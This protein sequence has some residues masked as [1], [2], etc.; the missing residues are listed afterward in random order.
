[1]IYPNRQTEIE[2]FNAAHGPAVQVQADGGLNRDV[3]VDGHSIGRQLWFAAP[4]FTGDRIWV[5]NVAGEFPTVA[6][7]VDAARYRDA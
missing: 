2:A 5:Q 1:M 4:R 6:E 3:L 7:A